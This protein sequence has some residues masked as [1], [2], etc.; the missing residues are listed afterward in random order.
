MTRRGFLERL[1]RGKY[2]IIKLEFKS[3]HANMGDFSQVALLD[4]SNG[5][6][7]PVLFQD[8]GV[9]I[10]QVLP[11]LVAI[12]RSPLLKAKAT[13][14]GSRYRGL[15][16]LTF[17]EQPELHLHPEMQADL[18]KSRAPSPSPAPQTARLPLS[19]TSW[20]T[21]PAPPLAWAI[22]NRVL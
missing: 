16:R 5:D 19:G 13:R 3:D 18:R 1:T 12:L 6:Q 21:I 10:S 22:N 11:I 8:A 20:A 4:L 2:K 14:F 7:V 17:I 9:G 15:S